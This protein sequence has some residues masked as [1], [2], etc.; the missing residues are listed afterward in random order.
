MDAWRLAVLALL[1]TATPVAADECTPA[2]AQV[3]RV[4]E[5]L[6]AASIRLAGGEVVRLAGIFVPADGREPAFAALSGM[7]AGAEIVLG[8]RSAKPDRYGRHSAQLFGANGVWIQ[9]ELLRAGRALVMTLP[10][11]RA[12][13][14]AMLQAEAAGRGASA[15]LWRNPDFAIARAENPS[16]AG[17]RNLYQIVEGRVVSVGKTQTTVYLDFGRNWATDFT[18]TI[19]TPDAALFES[20][21]LALDDLE[22][23]RVRVRG[24]LAESNGPMI[25]VDHREQ[26]EVLDR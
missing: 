5:V 12:C 6:D 25:K 10:D 21:G 8:N 4:S 17:R 26:I 11:E 23:R 2:G 7:A 16:F 14:Q 24:W 3:A 18:V 1:V 20:E 22:G 15:G 13:A 19:S 9:G